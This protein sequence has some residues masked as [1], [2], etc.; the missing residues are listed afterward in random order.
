MAKFDVENQARRP[1]NALLSLLM[2][3]N[4]FHI[5]KKQFSPTDELK[6]KASHNIHHDCRKAEST[7][8]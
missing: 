6:N 7:A 5:G 1:T 3:L 4:S 2:Q 8:F